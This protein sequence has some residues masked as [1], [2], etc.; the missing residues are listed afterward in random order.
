MGK[1]DPMVLLMA[2]GNISADNH[3]NKLSVDMLL[4]VIQAPAGGVGKQLKGHLE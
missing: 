1:T 3:H 2:I 4:L